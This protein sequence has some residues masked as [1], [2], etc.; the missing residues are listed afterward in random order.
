MPARFGKANSVW[1]R[2]DRWAKKGAWK[3]VMEALRD[4]D[5]EW[6]ILDSSTVRAHPCAAG[7]K[8]NGTAPAARP[9]KPW[10][11]PAATLAPKCM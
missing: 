7:A 9:S 11:V 6:L 2:F 4:P 1:R 10:A 8:K 5:L 3:R